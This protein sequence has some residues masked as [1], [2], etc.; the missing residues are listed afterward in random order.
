MT[1]TAIPY[2]TSKYDL[3]INTDAVSIPLANFS[4]LTFTMTSESTPATV[5]PFTLSFGGLSVVGEVLTLHITDSD[6]FLP[7]T[8]ANKLEGVVGGETVKLT[9]CEGN[10]ITFY[11]HV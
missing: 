7:D 10:T 1:C 11:A 5:I 9:L 3:I 6:I 2:T 8:Y 4:E